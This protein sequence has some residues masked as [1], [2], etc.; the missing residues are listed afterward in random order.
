VSE[1]SQQATTSIQKI[2]V[3]GHHLR[4]KVK[5]LIHEGNVR[6]I[7]IKDSDGKTILEM[8]VSVGVIGILVAPT[9]A[10]I[11][12]LG[13][14]AADY[15]IEVEREGDDHESVLT[16]VSASNGVQNER[17]ANNG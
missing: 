5:Q 12:A 7:T 11:G 17:R 3:K 2:D 10:T 4:P 6:R 16:A 8:P 13:A 1:L 9:M 15:S 14:L